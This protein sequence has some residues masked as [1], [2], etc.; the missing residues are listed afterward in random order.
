VSEMNDATP[1][2]LSLGGRLG[3][4]LK[5]TALYGGAAAVA[6]LLALITFPLLARHFSLSDYG[7]LDFFLVLASFMTIS[8]VFGQ[9]SAV[10]RHFY[11][12]EDTDERRQLIS[13][14]LFFQLTGLAVFIPLLWLGADWI[15]GFLV[16]TTDSVDLFRIVL[17]QLPFLLL[18]SFTQGLLK[19]TFARNQYLIMAIGFAALQTTSLV[20]AVVG[21]DVGV[22]GVLLVGLCTNTLFGLLGLVFIRRWLV[23]PSHTRHVREMLPYAVPIGMVCV[24][25]AFSPTLE[26]TLLVDLIGAE[27]LGLY[28]VATKIAVLTGLIVSAFQT[29]WGPFSLALHKQANAVVTYNLV[30]K[31]FAFF[32]CLIVLTLALL[33]QPLIQ[34]LASDRYV[35]AAVVVFPLA[36]GLA[37]QAVGWITEIGIGL[38]MRTHLSLYAY[39]AAVLVTVVGM[40]VLVPVLGLPGAGVGVMLGFLVRA[41]VASWLAQRAYPM[42]WKYGSTVILMSLTIIVGLLGTWI[43]VIWGAQAQGITLGLSLVT[44][45]VLGWKGMLAAHER[46]LVMAYLRARFS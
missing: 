36:M 2:N 34:V 20:I 1:T 45:V 10:A 3:F 46:S 29:A 44:L 8:F 15:A 18:I 5:D 37:I 40:V 19:W 12:T 39:A 11:E 6:S 28:A 38:S 32:M 31:L 7:V 13:Q 21:F 9:D 25:G 27:S 4:L 26:R 35:E 30:L 41:V 43:G 24:I 14:S 17:L 42:A 33:A 22:E 16:A 23:M